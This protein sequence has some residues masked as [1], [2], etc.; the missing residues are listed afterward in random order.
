MEEACP[1]LKCLQVFEETSH[2]PC[3]GLVFSLGVG[4][5]VQSPNPDRGGWSV[6]QKEMDSV[7]GE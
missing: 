3:Q 1:R 6:G 5:I 4:K 7:L 2:S